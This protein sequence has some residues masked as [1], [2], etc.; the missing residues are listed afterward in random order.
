MDNKSTI[1]IRDIGE[2]SIWGVACIFIE[3]EGI[4]TL[5]PKNKDDARLLF[6]HQFDEAFEFSY[7][8]NFRKNIAYIRSVKT[9]F[10][11][12]VQLITSY[13]IRVLDESSDISEIT[14]TGDAID[15]F[16][17]P[18]FFFYD[19]QQAGEEISINLA[20]QSI[21][22]NEWEI[23][24]EGTET[25]I[26]LSYGKIL[27][28]GIGSDLQL[29]PC[30]TASFPP[31]RDITF[32]IKVYQCIT[33][34]LRIVLYNYSCGSLK[35]QIFTC[36]KDGKS[37]NGFLKDYSVKKDSF[38]QSSPEANYRKLKPFIQQ[39]LQFAADNPV[40]SF[41]HYP[42]YG[43]RQ[44]HY[45]CN[46]IDCINIFS[47]F[48]SECHANKETFERADASNIESIKSQVITCVE[49]LNSRDI[50]TEE[51]NFLKQSKERISQI[52]TQF[53]QSKKITNA[54][55]QLCN[56]LESSTAHLLYRTYPQQQGVLDEKRIKRVADRLTG[57]RASIV[58]GDFSGELTPQDVQLFRFLEVL[59]YCML[60]RRI[61]LKDSEIEVFIGA[62][63]MCNDTV[64]SYLKT[65]ND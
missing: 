33:R 2:L 24:I 36:E 23:F 47:A 26:S 34:F 60:L 27:I 57:L 48:E 4:I 43:L 29:H 6:K 20:Y 8:S 25:T 58:H 38:K 59:T 64:Y 42:G 65:D 14:L 16:F 52:G 9:D 51:H 40:Y 46:T 63:F 5:I 18:A 53:G 62:V 50:S 7:Y 39:C 28:R 32:I 1:A 45:D 31:T 12:N 61:G 19:K 11:H 37:F 21:V 10:N 35:T 3:E 54:Y 22:A 17:N 44:T 13:I 56:A 15:C 30:L 41:V 55:Q 49:D